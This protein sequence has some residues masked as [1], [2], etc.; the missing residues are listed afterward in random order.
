VPGR[1]ER[2][3]SCAASPTCLAFLTKRQF[4]GRTGRS[5]PRPAAELTGNLHAGIPIN[6]A[7][8]SA[9]VRYAQHMS[10]ETDRNVEI[11]RSWRRDRRT[12]RGVARSRP[13]PCPVPGPWQVLPRTVHP[14]S[15]VISAEALPARLAGGHNAPPASLCALPPWRPHGRRAEQLRTNCRILRAGSGLK[16]SSAAAVAAAVASS[17]FLRSSLVC[18]RD[19]VVD[20]GRFASALSLALLTQCSGA[21]SNPSRG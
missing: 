19:G 2:S 20:G 13:A 10:P 17:R 16:H 14:V 18:A 8:P 4:A 21:G 7:E 3:R 12:G 9:E 11:W 5:S 1:S 6:A 15:T